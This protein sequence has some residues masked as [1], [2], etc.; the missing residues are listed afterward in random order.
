MNPTPETTIFE[1]TE[2]QIKHLKQLLENDL[3]EDDGCFRFDDSDKITKELLL[4]FK[5]P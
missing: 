5:K 3:E 4:I 1:L 2:P